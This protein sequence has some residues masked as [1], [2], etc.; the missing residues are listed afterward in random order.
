[1]ID[2][3]AFR[4]PSWAMFP[5]DLPRWIIAYILLRGE[6]GMIASFKRCPRAVLNQP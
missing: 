4:R 6:D 5:V 3:L 2:G 1:M